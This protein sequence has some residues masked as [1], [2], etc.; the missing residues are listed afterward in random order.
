MITEATSLKPRPKQRL[1]RKWK[2]KRKGGFTL[3][4]VLITISIFTVAIL[5]VAMS[6]ASLM[7][8][9]GTSLYTTV[10]TNLAQGKMEELKSR[11]VSVLPACPTYTTAGC[12][13][14]VTSGGLA[15]ARSWRVIVDSPVPGV[16]RID[17]Q[18]AWTHYNVP[19]TVTLT[20]GMIQ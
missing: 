15:L 9:S 2:L 16:N 4:E 17:V 3:I 5:G 12:S 11:L 1:G 10:A 18:I 20:G 13:D 14:T 6:A 8:A 19:H 7:K